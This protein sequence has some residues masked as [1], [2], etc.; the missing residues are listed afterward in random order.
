MKLILLN[1]GGILGSAVLAVIGVHA[2]IIDTETESLL[3][4]AENAIMNDVPNAI[5]ERLF[6][7]ISNGGVD[8]GLEFILGESRKDLGITKASKTMI[9]MSSELPVITDVTTD[10][11]SVDEEVVDGT[12]IDLLNDPVVCNQPYFVCL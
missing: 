9:R 8:D 2:V 4:S 1:E 11:A 12:F 5:D 6:L 10:V 7:G 3:F